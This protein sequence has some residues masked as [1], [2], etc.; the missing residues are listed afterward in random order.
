MSV[1]DNVARDLGHDLTHSLKL[2]EASREQAVPAALSHARAQLLDS[3]SWWPKRLAGQ[4][5][6]Q[7]ALAWCGTNFARLGVS[8]LVDEWAS[9]EGLIAK[10]PTWPPRAE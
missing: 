9:D 8:V 5:I 4:A 10:L 2:S 7:A 6:H 1:S 3:G